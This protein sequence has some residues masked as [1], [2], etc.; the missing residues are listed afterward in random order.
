ML[1]SVVLLLGVTP[2]LEAFSPRAPPTSQRP[3]V[4]IFS[5][6]VPTVNNNNN[7]NTPPYYSSRICILGGGFAGIQAALTAASLFK[8]EDERNVPQITL[9]DSKS[10]FVFLPLLY[11]LCV[12]DAT[13]DEVAPTYTSLLYG[14]NIEFLQRS[15]VGIDVNTSTVHLRM[16]QDNTT[17]TIQYDKLVLATGSDSMDF[18][19]IPGAKDCVVPFYTIEDCYRLRKIFYQ[20]DTILA[21]Q[22][23]ES[24]KIVVVGGGY[25]GVE[26]ALNVMQR[27]GKMDKKQVDMVLIHRGTHVLE[28]ATSYNRN[29]GQDRLIKAGIQILTQTSVD[30]IVPIQHIPNRFMSKCQLQVST[31]V[32][33]STQSTTTS[34]MVNA[35]LILWTAGAMRQNTPNRPGILN[36]KLPRDTKGR[37]VTYPTL[38]VK[39]YDNI[40]ALG[41]CSRVIRPSMPLQPY[42]A[43]AQVALQQA[44][45]VAWNLYSQHTS[46]GTEL[47]NFEYVDLGEM[48]TFGRDDA[49]ISSLQGRVQVNGASASTLRRMIYALR[50]PTPRQVWTA[51]FL[52][53]GQQIQRRRVKVRN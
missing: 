28:Y 11:E 39:G 10:R 24:L 40:Y 7:N 23:Q 3:S 19:H 6:K 36:S 29:M 35:D 5:A 32:M 31:R 17:Q 47:L 21:T 14:S 13:L 48:L 30:A 8:K 51:L 9:I 34:S 42:P 33:G 18:T 4:R 2:L 46:N 53:V 22:Q 20:L 12:G 15:I 26:L 50:M 41:D 52:Q 38:Q 44:T 1:F 37:I 27:L 16:M 49:S 25:S 43:T 45:L